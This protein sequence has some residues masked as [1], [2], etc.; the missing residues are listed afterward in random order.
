MSWIDV[1]MDGRKTRVAV[2][3]D[4]NAVWVSS[5]GVTKRLSPES[6]AIPQAEGGDRELR[7]PMTG[8]VVKVAATIG[9]T[10]Q[11]GESLVVLEAMKMEYRIAAPRDG[12]VE[13]VACRE[14][15]RVDLGS[16]LVT[17]AP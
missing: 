15:D 4:G 2:V 3:R 1:D 14:G 5:S 13:S 10:V 8:R 7:A 11:R 16:V 9:A 12:V 6:S 17:L